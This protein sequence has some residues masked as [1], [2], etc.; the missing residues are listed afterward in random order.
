MAANSTEV[1]YGF[2]QFGSV[3]NG[4]QTP[5]RPPVGKVFVAITFI[6]DTRLENHGGLVGANDTEIGLGYVSTEMPNGDA[7]ISHNATYTSETA[8]AGSGQHYVDNND[9]FSRGLTIY[10]RWSEV[11]AYSGAFIAYIGE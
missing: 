6:T 1:I 4:T 11:H 3:F 5:V 2:G 10:G 8:V 7:N 9:I